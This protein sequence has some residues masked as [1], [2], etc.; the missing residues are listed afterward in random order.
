VTQ[1][2]GVFTILVGVG[3]V[4]LGAFMLFKTMRIVSNGAKAE[5]TV[6][7][8]E[9]KTRTERRSGERDRTVADHW[10][11]VSFQDRNEQPYTFKA[12]DSTGRVQ[13]GEKVQV[14]YNLSN[15]SEARLNSFLSVWA[16][17]VIPPIFG[18]LF[19]GI[20]V[21]ITSLEG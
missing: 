3:V 13:V 15:P 11:T 18:I 9:I 7:A 5:G 17:A 19:M 20:G 8:V 2:L 6:T 21:F 16:A 14:L 10:L 4:A 12:G 1:M